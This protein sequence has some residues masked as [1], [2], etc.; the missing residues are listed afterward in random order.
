M[1]VSHRVL[2][3]KLK[4]GMFV[5]TNLGNYGAEMKNIFLVESKFSLIVIAYLEFCYYR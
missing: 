4:T 3:I 2:F 5:L 1:V